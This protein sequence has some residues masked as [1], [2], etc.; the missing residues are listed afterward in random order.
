MLLYIYSTMIDF[1]H[2]ILILLKKRAFFIQNVRLS[3][4][5]IP[6]NLPLLNPQKNSD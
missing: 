4:L 5:P 1:F 6:A 2:L 3:R